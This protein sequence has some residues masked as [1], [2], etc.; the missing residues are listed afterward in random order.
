MKTYKRIATIVVFLTIIWT[1]AW[2]APHRCGSFSAWALGVLGYNNWMVWLAL[3]T[4]LVM[5]YVPI[6]DLVAFGFYRLGIEKNFA[7][8]DL[9]PE[10]DPA[11][12]SP[13]PM[14]TND[15]LIFVYPLNIVVGTG[16]AV[17]W[18]FLFVRC[19]PV[20]PGSPL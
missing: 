18:W 10:D 19:W 3:A 9:Y 7:G 5:F 12:S 11:N 20:G 16:L 4:V 15:K 8:Q 6:Y 17:A 2:V 1:V 14:T 13:P